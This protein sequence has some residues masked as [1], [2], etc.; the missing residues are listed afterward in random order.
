MGARKSELLGICLVK[1]TTKSTRGDNSSLQTF[2]TQ[3]KNF[4]Y[5]GKQILGKKFLHFHF[6]FFVVVT[7]YI[8]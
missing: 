7:V 3:I 6:F 2:H 1:R 8:I 5:E 4:I